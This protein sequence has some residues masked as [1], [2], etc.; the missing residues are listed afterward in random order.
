MADAK[1]ERFATLTALARY[2]AVAEFR[3]E[4][5]DASWRSD[6]RR[7]REALDELS[8]AERCR[9]AATDRN[10]WARWV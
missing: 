7:L 3:P 5:S 8:F 10:L 2:L 9:L 4:V 1:N 6:A